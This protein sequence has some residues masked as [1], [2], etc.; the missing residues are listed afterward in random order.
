MRGWLEESLIDLGLHRQLVR[1]THEW[2]ESGRDQSFLLR[3][4]RLDRF[5]SWTGDTPLVLTEDEQTYLDSSVKSRKERETIQRERQEQEDSLERQSNRRLKALVAVMAVALVVALALTVAAFSFARQAE[6][7]RRLA[8]AHELSS[9][10]IA[11]LDLDPERSILLALEAARTSFAQDGTVLPEVEGALRR[12]IQA[13]RVLLSIP[14]SGNLAYNPEGEMLAIGGDQGR[15]SLWDAATGEQIRELLGH[16]ELISDL[17]FSQDGRILVTSGFDSKVYLWQVPSGRQL[18]EIT[19]GGE[20]NAVA[21]SPEND[22]LAVAPRDGDIII[23]D[24]PNVLDQITEQFE[25][26]KLGQQTSRL[27]PHGWQPAWHTAPTAIAS[28][29]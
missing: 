16:E 10:A 13:D 21:L 12:A 5:D 25:P 20:V 27:K 7:Q 17:A 6:Q 3:G 2:I 23:W 14:T 18:G 1:A 29:P 11:N 24:I 9:A 4:A 28:Q 19:I 26:E 15:L 8:T 22:Q